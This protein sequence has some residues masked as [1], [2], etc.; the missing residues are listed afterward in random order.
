MPY[1]KRSA[2]DRVS[3]DAIRKPTAEDVDHEP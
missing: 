2:A 1:H 3:H